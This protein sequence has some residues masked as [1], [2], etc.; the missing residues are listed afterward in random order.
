MSE[1]D[2]VDPD[3]AVKAL[4]SMAATMQAATQDEKRAFIAACAE[5]AERLERGEIPGYA[6]TAT[7]IRSLPEAMGLEST[8]K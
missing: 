7:F 5:E 6:K 3:S 8:A 1:D 4:E 2:I